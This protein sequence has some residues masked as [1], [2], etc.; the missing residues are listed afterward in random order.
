[1]KSHNTYKSIRIQLQ[2][3]K[4]IQQVCQENQLTLADLMG[5]FMH[6]DTQP[7]K[8][9]RTRKGTYIYKH[10][11]GRYIIYCNHDYYGTYKTFNDARRVRDVLIENGWNKDLL[12]TICERLGVKRC[13]K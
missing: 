11:S 9:H 12:D 6:Y 5:L 13:K 3:G 8:A 10:S 2:N 7:R 4:T 1:M